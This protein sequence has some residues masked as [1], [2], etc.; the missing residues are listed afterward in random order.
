[1]PGENFGKAMLNTVLVAMGGAVGAAAR[2]WLSILVGRV[3]GMPSPVGTLIVNILG[4]ALMGVLFVLL[5]ERHG[6]M[7][8]RAL[9]MSGLLGGFTTFSAFSIETVSLMQEGSWVKAASYVGASVIVCVLACWAGV[10][11]TRAA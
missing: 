2:Y 11:I 7:A 8:W 1:M 5:V 10:V 3:T 6:A 9:L 4:C